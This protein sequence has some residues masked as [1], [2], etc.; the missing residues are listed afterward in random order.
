[1]IA[2]LTQNGNRRVL[3][4]LNWTGDTENDG[5]YLPLVENVTIRF[6]I[7][8]G[9]K[10]RRVSSFLESPLRQTQVGQEL[11]LRIP[12]IEAYQAVTIELQ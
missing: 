7:P 12:R 1:M 10:V 9:T 2:N 5:G 8:D 11:E 4:L 3:H 6:R